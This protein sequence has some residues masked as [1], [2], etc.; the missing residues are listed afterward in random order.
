LIGQDW[1]NRWLVSHPNEGEPDTCF[2]A[3]GR[4]GPHDAYVSGARS[5]QAHRDGGPSDG[6]EVG[7]R[8]GD[9]ILPAETCIGNGIGDCVANQRRREGVKEKDLAIP[10]VN[11]K[12]V[13]CV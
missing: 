8:E 12:V 2:L 9:T 7:S 4:N 6:D 1:H 3:R 11:V 5:D 10:A 13:P